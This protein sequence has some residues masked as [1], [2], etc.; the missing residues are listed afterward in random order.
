FRTPTAKP[1]MAQ[2]TMLEDGAV[3]EYFQEPREKSLVWSLLSPNRSPGSGVFGRR[4][5]AKIAR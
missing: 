2:V 5:V 1:V 4:D 3:A